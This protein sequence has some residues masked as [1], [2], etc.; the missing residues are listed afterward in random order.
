MKAKETHFGSP[1]AHMRP[2]EVYLTENKQESPTALGRRDAAAYASM[3]D[4]A[5][6]IND[7]T[8]QNR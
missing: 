8:S 1:I 4:T 7:L 6:L 3:R 5:Q 2:C